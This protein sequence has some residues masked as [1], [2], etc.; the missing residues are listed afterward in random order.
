M[1]IFRHLVIGLGVAF[2]ALGVVSP[3]TAWADVISDWYEVA[4]TA[5]L[6]ATRTGPARTPVTVHA[7]SQ[8]ALAMFEAANTIERRYEAYFEP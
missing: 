6:R 3:Q 1:G 2:A 8:V 5:V 7:R 4:D